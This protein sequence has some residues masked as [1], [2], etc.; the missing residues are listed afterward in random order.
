ML[1]KPTHE[2]RGFPDA[3]GLQSSQAVGQRAVGCREHS[4]VSTAAPESV[5]V[6][7][8]SLDFRPAPLTRLVDQRGGSL[9]VLRLAPGPAD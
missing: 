5:E 7:I 1:P 2:T 8:R 6:E 9:A 4:D 3:V